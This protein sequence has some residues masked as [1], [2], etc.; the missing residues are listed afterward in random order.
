[1]FGEYT[2]QIIDNPGYA[3]SRVFLFK[4]Q[5]PHGTEFLTHTG[6]RILV[7]P[8]TELKHEEL[9]FADLDPDQLQA[10]ANALSKR[11][12]K[13]NAD[14]IAEGKLLATEKHLED[15]RKIVFE[16]KK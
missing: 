16:G 14:S 12:I 13:T 2:V 4:K 1:M 11:G 3:N 5:G 7:A 6:D 8:A 10:L 9:Y 15:M